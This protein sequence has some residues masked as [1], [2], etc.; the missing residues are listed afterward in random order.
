MKR[1]KWKGGLA[2]AAALCLALLLQACSGGGGGSNQGASSTAP[3]P[4]AASPASPAPSEEPSAGAELAP[5]EVSIVYQAT[6]QQDDALIEEKLNEYFKDK[7][8]ATI[9]LRPIASSEY[10]QKTELMM[11]TGEQMDLIFAASWLNYFGNVTKGAYLELDELLD[12]YGQGIKQSLNPL[13]LEAPRFEGK[14]YAI[15]QNKE[16]TQGLSFTYRKDIVD[17]Y[18]IPIEQINRMED[19]R[20]WFELLKEKE[21]GLILNIVGS[22]SQ[23]DNL[24]YETNSNYR[25]IGPKLSKMPLFLVDYKAADPKVKSLLDPEIVEINKKEYELYRE[26]YEKGYTNADAATNTA[27]LADLRKQGQ[28]WMQR[29]TW[30]PGSDIELKLS[31]DNKYDFVSHVVAEPVVDTDAATGSL[32]AISRTSK[33]PE[34]AMMVLNYLHTDPYVINLL[35]HGIEDKHYKKVGDNRIELIPD[36]GYVPN[37]HWVLGSQMLNYLKPGQP[38][39]MYESWKTFN[40]EATRFPLLGFAFDDTKV[41]NE[42]SQLAGVMSEYATLATGAAPNP[43]ALLEERNGKLK[44]AGIEKVQAELQAQIDAWLLENKN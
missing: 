14:L 40:E 15:P 33:D 13:Y 1:G 32:L 18:N 43:S 27:N 37:V 36:S 7:I 10:K 20:P 41:K 30:K 39:D 6:P 44:A 2:L 16:I 9:D 8:N 11:N 28:L 3:S 29:A 22:G 34:R 38:D 5:Y 12:K 25:S 42:V 26:Y 21:P 24:M 31:T 23:G 4:S 35:V 19:L 17:K